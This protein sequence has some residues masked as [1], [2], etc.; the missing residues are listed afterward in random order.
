VFR[1]NLIEKMFSITRGGVSE[2]EM[3]P[4]EKQNAHKNGILLFKT[5][6]F[7]PMIYLMGII[8]K[9]LSNVGKFLV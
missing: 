1:N 6:T 7:F 2:I 4:P 3:L 9:V 5:P 8:D